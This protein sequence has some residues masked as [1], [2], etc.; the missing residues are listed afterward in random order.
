MLRQARQNKIL[1]LINEKEIETQEELCKEL[2]NADFKVTQATV[3]R[4]VRELG[5]YKISGVQKRYRYT[6]VR[7]RE[8]DLPDRMRALFEAGVEKVENVGNV[9]VTKTMAGYGA[10]AGAVIDLL[11]FEEVVGSIAGDDTVFSLCNTSEDAEKTRDKLREIV[12]TI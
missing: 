9:V 2:E 10:N 8:G 11:N 5:L 4:D 6:A 7:K 12:G 1:E 3:S